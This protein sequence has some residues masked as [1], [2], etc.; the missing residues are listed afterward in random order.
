MGIN[1]TNKQNPQINKKN[2]S[3]E[4]GQSDFL[5]QNFKLQL[6]YLLKRELIRKGHLETSCIL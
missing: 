3:L 6:F 1:K 2:P 4:Y 5:N